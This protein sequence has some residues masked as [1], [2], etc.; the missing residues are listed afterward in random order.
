MSESEAMT[1]VK[2][3]VLAGTGG[4]GKT[5][6]S[7]AYALKQALAGRRVLVL[8]ID[9]ARRLA[10]A[11]GIE[12]SAGNAQ[13]I[14]LGPET[15]G[16]LD[17]AML[18]ARMTFDHI[19]Q[20]F[21]PNPDIARRIINNDFYR[22]AAGALGGS[23][24][25]MAMEALLEAVESGRWDLVVLDT[26]PSQNAIDFLDAPG[27]MLAVLERGTLG[28]LITP[29]FD[30][31]RAGTRL[32][33]KGG[34]ALFRVFERLTGGDVLSGLSEFVTNFADL[35]PG[36]K[37]RARRVKQLLTSTNCDFLLV[38]AP[39]TASIEPALRYA[40]ELEERG[41]R[42]SFII[43]NRCAPPVPDEGD[44]GA[45]AQLSKLLPILPEH[46]LRRLH[47]A[48]ESLQA[49]R[50]ERYRRQSMAIDR[51]AEE[52]A[53]H[54]LLQLAESP[55]PPHSLEELVDLARRIP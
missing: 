53:P 11:M 49:E 3:A 36:F 5:T 30:A 40:H 16:S 26:P 13:S 54:T 29:A 24:E 55:S 35:L 47:K 10:Q 31:A 6:L 45:A 33:G 1:E 37:D 42:L 34:N 7:A 21:S 32:F 9:P 43:V 17:A 25:Y 39:R 52:L 23:Q 41:H 51:L 46:I 15:S 19:V 8:T 27:R 14:D 22:R 12:P 18:D 28:W 2:V 48:L 50:A 20:R 4:V 38:T 44:I